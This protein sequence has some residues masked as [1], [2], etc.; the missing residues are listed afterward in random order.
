MG[1][2]KMQCSWGV[3]MAEGGGAPPPPPATACTCRPPPTSCPPTP[4]QP[5]PTPPNRCPPAP[6]RSAAAGRPAP[7][8][9]RASCSW[10]WAAQS[11]GTC[12]PHACSSTM[13]MAGVC[14]GRQMLEGWP[15]RVA[16]AL[17]A[18]VRCCTQG[19]QL[20]AALTWPGSQRCA[21][22]DC[23]PAWR[24]RGCSNG[25]ARWGHLGQQQCGR[26]PCRAAS[27]GRTS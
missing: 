11:Q 14:M 24:W 10:S 8:P 6:G 22:P 2:H 12:T 16:Q 17:Q 21:C 13:D 18:E 15:G 4:T 9:Q 3:A 23:G 5:L 27:S 20:P 1:K 7:R 19:S 25:K 26:P